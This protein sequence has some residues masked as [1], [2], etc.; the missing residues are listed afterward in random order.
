MSFKKTLYTTIM[1]SF[2]EMN[3]KRDKCIVQ[4]AKS[5]F[6]FKFSITQNCVT[7]HYREVF[8]YV[9]RHFRKLSLNFTKLKFKSSE[10]KIRTTKNLNKFVLYELIDLTKRLEFKSKKISD[11]KT[12][13]S[14]YANERS[15]FEQSKSTYVVD[16]SKEC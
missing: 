1:R 8:L 5:I 12:K 14:N 11:L 9:M 4:E 6:T 10:K 13:Y 7:L 3:Q 2:F 15:S 16:E